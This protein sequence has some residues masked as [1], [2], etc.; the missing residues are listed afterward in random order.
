MDEV[1]YDSLIEGYRQHQ[2]AANCVGRPNWVP[3]PRV[4]QLTDSTVELN[5][6]VCVLQ[7]E[8]RP[9]AELLIEDLQKL[10]GREFAFTRINTPGV[11]TLAIDGKLREG[12]YTIISSQSEIKLTASDAATLAWGTVT[13]VQSV[14]PDGMTL[15]GLELRDWPGM[16]YRG[17]M[18]DCGRNVHTLEDLKKLIR[19]CRWNKIKYFQLHLSDNQIF[20]VKSQKYPALN[21]PGALTLDECR[22]LEAFAVKY[23]VTLVPEL[24]VPGHS[25]CLLQMMSDL[26]CTPSGRNTICAGDMKV[27]GV[28]KE[29]ISELCGVFTTSEYFHIGAD[30]VEF[31]PWEACEVCRKYA[32]EHDLED[33]EALFRDFI[34]DLNEHVKSC[35]KQTIVWEGFRA[36]GKNLVPDD[37]IVMV[38]ESL[39][40]TPDRLLADGYKVINASWQP[41]YV[42]GDTIGWP[43]CHIFNWH[44]YRWENWWEKSAA[45]PNAIEVARDSAVMGAQFCT[46]GVQ[47]GSEVAVL[48]HRLPAYAERLWNPES[49]DFRDLQRRAAK[50]DDKLDKI[51]S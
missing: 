14:A 34:I 28:I 6:Q 44:P 30:E 39:Y 48:R 5:G 25:E 42:E 47:G 19:L 10:T 8:A 33:S 45:C 29:L 27:R 17:L 16:D 18:V 36:G 1:I 20:M 38:F 3:L 13:L 31:E 37:V 43:S 21:S 51:I 15:P 35:G 22:E 11:V 26:G 49:D 7:E 50:W 12:E 24:D 46:W 9:A 41:L 40:Y 32:A 23:A 2:A 4:W